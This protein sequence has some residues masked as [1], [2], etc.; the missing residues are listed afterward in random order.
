MQVLQPP[1]PLLLVPVMVCWKIAEEVYVAVICGL[2]KKSQH[3]QCYVYTDMYV[4]KI[5]GMVRNPLSSIK[6][7]QHA[8]QF[9]WMDDYWLSFFNI[10]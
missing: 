1:P 8:I 2:D 6:S 10:Y 7:T 4:L 9:R 3:G 5:L